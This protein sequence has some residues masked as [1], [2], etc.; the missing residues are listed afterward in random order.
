M[1]PPGNLW[2]PSKK[3]CESGPAIW[4]AIA[5]LYDYMSEELFYIDR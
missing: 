3:L 2:V 1:L 5:Y 4:P